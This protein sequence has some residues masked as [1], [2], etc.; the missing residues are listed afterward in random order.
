MQTTPE[1]FLL[2]I[3]IY[4][5]I[6]AHPT[7]SSVQEMLE[8]WQ[9]YQEACIR[10]MTED[11]QPTGLVCNRTFDMYACW[12]DALPNTSARV[13]C[14]W[15]LPW[16]QQVQDGFVF[17]KCGTDG[18]WVVDAS[19]LPWRDHSQCVGPNNDLPFQRHLW[20]LEQFR[21]MYT[22]GYSVSL[23]SLLV[24]LTLL[25]AFRKLRCMRNYL[26]MNLFLSYVL[27]AAAILLRDALLW[28]HFPR[29]L[30]VDLSDLP[31]REQAVT[32][33]RLAQILTQYCV[34]ANYFWLLV[35]GIYLHN[36][37]GPMAFLEESYFPAYLF[38][39]WGAPLF[40]VIPWGIM[41][42]LY[43]NNECW[44]R[45]DNLGY[46]WIIRCPILVSILVNFVIFIRVLK[47]LNSKLRAQQMHYTDY[48]YRLA[49]STLTLIPLL[50]THGV[51]FALVT[52]EQA[53][54]T[55]RYIKFFF[56][57]FFNSFQGL[58]V[59]TLYC[60]VNKEVQSEIQRKWQMC[61][62]DIS[63][64]K[65]KGRCFSLCHS[66]CNQKPPTRK[67]SCAQ[68]YIQVGPK[69]APSDLDNGTGAPFQQVP[70]NYNSH[71]YIPIRMKAENELA[72]RPHLQDQG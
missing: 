15:Y 65:R 8:A 29:D 5:T 72:Q 66:W 13:P 1:R 2:L 61:Q 67:P 52:E 58:L 60:F 45:N 49:K 40:F 11:P 25:A 71:W 44:E 30:Q 32:G 3:Q 28:L 17:Q 10:K 62:L 69:V 57:L 4:W 35:E 37:L 46:W 47:V 33:C 50:G 56:E 24:A 38:L 18:Q 42:Y 12:D 43:E 23:V 21:R 41:R 53:L 51:A 64:L 63:L 59:S 54:G 16:H 36:L 19:G 14:P 22:V 7:G 9:G 39:G 55:L 20:I 68:I 34:C 26:H 6:E 70:A 31:S 48:K 27:R